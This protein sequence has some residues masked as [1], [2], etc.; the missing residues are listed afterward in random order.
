MTS[1]SKSVLWQRMHEYYDQLGTE[2]WED[3]V[4]PNQITTNTYLANIYARLIVAQIQDYLAKYGKPH[5]DMAFHIIELGAGHGRLSFYLL[6]YLQEAF[7]FFN[8]PKKWLK[9]VMTDISLKSLQVWKEHHALKKFIE[10]G[11]LDMAVFNAITDT[12]LKLHICDA[13]ITISA[14]KTPTTIIANYIFD[15][16]EQD[17]FQIIN[18]RL[19]EVELRIENED[20]LPRDDLNAYFENAKYAYN[21]HPIS[22]NYY[23]NDPEL[24]AILQQYETELDNAAFL[25]PLGAFKCIKNL[26]RNAQGPLM[27]L[28]S[29]KGISDANL[30][31]EDDDPD[32]DFH[33]SISMTVNFDALKRFTNQNG[34]MSLTM[35]NQGADF[36]VAAFLYNIDYPSSHTNYAFENSL[37]TYSPQ[38][39][40]DICYIDDEI[41]PAFKTIDS[42]VNLL[43][44]TEW[45]PNI[46][47]DYQEVLIEKIEQTDDGG[48]LIGSVYSI[49]NGLDRIWRFFFKLEKDQNIPFV[50]GS[51]LYSLDYSEKALEFYQHA[52]E[53]FGVDKETYL[54]I[55][56]AQVAL[57]NNVEAK[58]A[59]L[60]ALEIAPDYKDAKELLEEIQ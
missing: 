60:K 16:L 53:F 38:D 44:L 17:A 10:N 29:D 25:I 48:L 7:Q 11:W 31:P 36:Q 8:W 56:L 50:I 30:F 51:I 3:E 32:I 34:G 40:F 49:L 18:H 24:N 57:E 55:A 14:L 35:G 52:I 1:L 58:K 46:F 15:T 20:K 19:H 59:L 39:L 33:G 12:E 27:Y 6:T 22:A 45:D 37:S 4:V 42:I 47:Y 13:T 26:K 28:V 5:D 54:N 41:N 43:N 9:Y 23:E 2:V 21:K